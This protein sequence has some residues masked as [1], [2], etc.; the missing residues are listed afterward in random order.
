MYVTSLFHPDFFSV[1]PDTLE[2]IEKTIL[3]GEKMH[4]DILIVH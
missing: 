3:L 4:N 1:S 2:I